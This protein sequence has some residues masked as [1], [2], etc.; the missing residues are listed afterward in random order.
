M[1]DEAAFTFIDIP[2]LSFFA[3]C[4]WLGYYLLR[5]GYH[6][7]CY[8]CT[9]LWGFCMSCVPDWSTEAWGWV[10]GILAWIIIT[11]ICPRLGLWLLCVAVTAVIFVAYVVFIA[12]VVLGFLSLLKNNN[13][14]K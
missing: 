13:S 1:K 14:D 10:L 12:F 4:A 3:L 9:N 6:L 5:W 7:A 8:A 2:I 11:M